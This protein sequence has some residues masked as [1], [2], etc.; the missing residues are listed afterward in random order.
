MSSLKLLTVTF[1]SEFPIDVLLFCVAFKCLI[2][3]IRAVVLKYYAF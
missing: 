2:V 1:F 3:F